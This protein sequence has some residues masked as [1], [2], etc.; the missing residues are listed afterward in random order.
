MSSLA[1]RAGPRMRDS[2]NRNMLKVDLS[3]G[4]GLI[5]LFIQALIRTM[6]AF[7]YVREDHEF[8]DTIPPLVLVIRTQ[9]VRRFLQAALHLMGTRNHSEQRH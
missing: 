1:S 5:K 9:N 6:R 4:R 8:P 7:V 2:K 3:I